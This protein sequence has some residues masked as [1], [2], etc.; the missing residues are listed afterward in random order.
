MKPCPFCGSD[1]SY[2]ACWTVESGGDYYHYEYARSCRNCGAKG[3]N[4]ITTAG[5]IEQWNFRHQQ[6]ALLEALE[7]LASAI[8]PDVRTYNE[9]NFTEIHHDILENFELRVKAAIAQAK[10]EADEE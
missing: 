7:Y 1:D 4:K 9:Y 6:A 8:K 5:A 10:G 3:P 2:L